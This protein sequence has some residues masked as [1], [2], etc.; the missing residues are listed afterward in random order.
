MRTKSCCFYVVSSGVEAL[1]PVST[2]GLMMMEE[3]VKRNS[4]VIEGGSERP[5]L[6]VF[7]CV[8]GVETTFALA[9]FLF[10]QLAASRFLSNKALWTNGPGWS[11][12]HFFKDLLAHT[13]KFPILVFSHDKGHFSLF[14][15]S[16][17]DSVRAC[18][19]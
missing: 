9:E 3:S 14:A 8:C 12:S 13:L 10:E 5:R 1:S 2:F 16:G 11:S 17:S 18:A 6:R 19:W 4:T 7:V 15:A